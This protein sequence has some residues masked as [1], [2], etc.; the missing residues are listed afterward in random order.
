MKILD[1]IL[2]ILF[3][4]TVS[5]TQTG[6]FK[7][8]KT[9]EDSLSNLKVIGFGLGR[10]HSPNL[11]KEKAKQNAIINLSDQI[12]GRNFSY[13][14]ST[15]S[16]KF[17]TTF[18]GTISGSEVVESIYIGDNTYFTTLSAPLPEQ[19][20]DKKDS[21]MMETEYRTADLEKSLHQKYQTAV[22]ELKTKHFKNQEILEGKIYLTDIDVK[23]HQETD[24]FTIKMQVLLEI[25]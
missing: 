22:K 12:L 3:L 2:V 9:D 11:A 15:G 1:L 20:L 18:R 16:T 24:V 14:R 6:D 13:N 23:Y 25:N 19:M 8:I 21:F 10:S 17:S 4:F 5:C 7:E